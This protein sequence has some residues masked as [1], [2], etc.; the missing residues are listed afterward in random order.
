MATVETL[1][2]TQ[3]EPRLK[4]PTIFKYFDALQPGEEFVIEND[5]DPKPLYYELIGERGDIFTWEYLEK[6][7]EW[8]IVRICK[9]P[10]ETQK[11]IERLVVT[12]IEPKFKHPTIF[13]WFD[14][15][16]AGESFIIEND[17]DP[18]PLYYELLAERGDIFTWEYLEKGPEVFEVQIAKNP[19]SE[20]GEETVGS[21]AAKDIRKAELL[22]SKGIDFSCGGDK[23][24]K[25]ASAD[26]G[27]SENELRSALTEV[28]K[29]PPA[30]SF[31]YD[32]WELDFLADY[33]VN[34]HH[35]YVKENA[36]NLNDMAI[37]VAEHHGDGHPELNRLATITYHFLQDLLDHIVKEEEVLFPVIKQIVAKTKNAES[38]TN[39]RIGSLNEP[40]SLLLKEHDIANE[41][42]NFF[43]KLT[44]NY[45]LPEGACNSYR[46][47]FQKMQE[48][49]NDFKAHIH[50]EN[51]ILFPKALQMDAELAKLN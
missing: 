41:D 5:H 47:L 34:T 7:P 42:L 12:T 36:E 43:R 22:K 40:I 8:F 20:T 15:L 29:T 4:H 11:A 9:N 1:D 3:I 24:V 38:E 19:V 2:V 6:G 33:I 25:E 16:K 26:A 30:P 51:N 46:Y 39:Y 27:I 32:K 18:K 44:D 35:R 48:F 45:T 13:K 37:K 50:L 10:L 49:E 31:D 23:T 28:S 14:A 17:H 21:I